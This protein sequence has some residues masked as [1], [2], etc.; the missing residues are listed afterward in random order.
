MCPLHQA[1]REALEGPCTE[2]SLGTRLPVKSSSQKFIQAGQQL[3]LRSSLSLTGDS[4][5]LNP[6]TLQTGFY[7]YM[8]PLE[9]DATTCSVLLDQNVLL[10]QIKV[11]LL[12]R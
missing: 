11:F 8:L 2:C 7:N 4:S 6:R 5:L 10:E 9:T 12:S 3:K 1:V